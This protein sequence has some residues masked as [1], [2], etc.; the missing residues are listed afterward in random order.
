MIIEALTGAVV[1]AL[2]GSANQRTIYKTNTVYRTEK[3]E[4]KHIDPAILLEAKK[5]REEA[6]IKEL[7][8]FYDLFDSNRVVVED[9]I[10]CKSVIVED[11][12]IEITPF[13]KYLFE[14]FKTNGWLEFN[15]LNFT[16]R[17]KKDYEFVRAYLLKE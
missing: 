2:V 12:E 1:G 8:E 10:R 6:L 17:A 3:A 14:L 5:A 11:Y 9:I 15:Y 16:Y 13:K 4:P 7:R